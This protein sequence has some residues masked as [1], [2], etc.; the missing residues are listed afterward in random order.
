M[1]PSSIIKPFLVALL[2]FCIGGV[3]IGWFH[4]YPNLLALI[5]FGFV[6]RRYL[7]DASNPIF[8]EK[9]LKIILGII[10]S[11]TLGAFSEWLGTEHGWWIY[12]YFADAT[13]KVPPWVPFA[14]VIVYQIFFGLEEKWLCKLDHQKR[15]FAILSLFLILPSIG[16]MI[17]MNMG[18][19]HYTY[20]PQF[21]MMPVQAVLLIALV[22]LVLYFLVYQFSGSKKRI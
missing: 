10:F 14:W 13:I 18:T 16:E 4:Y 12:H 3:I 6:L 1:N 22:H 21:L 20:Q 17:A 7:K 9:K 8:V 19:W 5:L 15:W 11:F 2:K